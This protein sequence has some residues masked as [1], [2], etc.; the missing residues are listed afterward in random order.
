MEK[1]LE[2][3]GLKLSAVVSKLLGKSSRRILDAVCDGLENPAE[4]TRLGSRL[5]AGRAE[6]ERV[7][8]GG[9]SRVVLVE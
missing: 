9:F 2:R 3:T 4:P 7:L 1:A 6:L 5:K 8:A